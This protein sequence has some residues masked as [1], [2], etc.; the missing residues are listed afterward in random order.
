MK[1]LI[2]AFLLIITL[3][4]IGCSGGGTAAT[5]NSGSTV[6][7]V[8][9]TGSPL[10]GAVYLKDSSIPAKELSKAIASDGSFSFDVDGLTKPFIL[11]AVG[12]SGGVNYTLYTVVSASGTANIN[13]LSHMAAM[14]ANSGQDLTVLYDNL[15]PGTLQAIQALYA[16]AL[17][18][19][20]A[21]LKPLFDASGLSVVDPVGGAYVADHKG[22][23]AVFD[24]LS[25]VIHGS[26]ITILNRANNA[27]IYTSGAGAILSQNFRL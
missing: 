10:V 7:G 16:D 1:S 22:L 5:S 18:S 14:A 2:S 21:K 3:M 26:D 23:D 4:M 15:T 12:T 8:A 11:K 9:A 20:V 27:V 6:S 25:F 13:P 17:A 19:V 24:L